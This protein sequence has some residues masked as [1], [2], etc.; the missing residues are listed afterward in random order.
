M[1]SPTP[2][3]K[4]P[5][6]KKPTSGRVTPK[7]TGSAPA[8]RTSGADEDLR[9]PGA[10]SRYTPPIPQSE[11]VSPPWVAP[12][13][14]FFLGAGILMIVLNYMGLLPGGTDNWYLI[15]GL[16][17]ILAGIITATRLH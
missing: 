15:A 9:H 10:S 3:K 7:G 13:M 16:G 11:K 2:P 1:S 8:R 5:P 12:L 6:K 17:V 4:T 14:F